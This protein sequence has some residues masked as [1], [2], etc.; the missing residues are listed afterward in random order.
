MSEAGD[1]EALLMPLKVASAAVRASTLDTWA[2]RS[3]RSAALLLVKPG[4]E[5]ACMGTEL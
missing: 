3:S 4:S 5:A 2:A 1:E